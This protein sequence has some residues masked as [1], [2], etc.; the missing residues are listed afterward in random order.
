MLNRLINT[1]VAGGGGGCTDIVDNYD[2]FGGNGVA[3]YQ[4]NGDATDVST[5]YNGSWSGTE[6]Y[7]T[8]VFGQAANFSGTNYIDTSLR[9]GQNWSVS[10]WINSSAF[11]DQQRAAQTFNSIDDVGFQFRGE[12]GGAML[13]WATNN[14]SYNEI[15]SSTI[16][17]ANTWYHIVGTYDY[18]NNIMNLYVNGQNDGS[19]LATE[20]VSSSTYPLRIGQQVGGSDS[21]AYKLDQVRIFNE[22]L[23]PLEVEALYTEELCICDGTVDTL[24]ILG[25]GSCIATYQL[26]GN[27]NDLSGNYSGT[28]TDVSYGVGE[29]DLAGVFNG[30]SSR[31]TIN[32]LAGAGNFFGQIQTFTLSIWFKT[33]STSLSQMFT[34]SAGQSFNLELNI[35]ETL[36]KLS[37]KTRYSDNSLKTTTSNASNL[38]DGAWHNVVVTMSGAYGVRNVYID[39]QFDNSITLGGSSF[40]ATSTQNVVFFSTGSSTFFLNG[41]LDQ[42]RIFNK[43]LS[44]GE[45]TTLYNETACTKAACTG[46]TNTLDILGDGSCI[47][48]YPLDGSPADLSGNYNGVQTDVTYPVG[49]F[50]LAAKFVNVSGTHI[51]TSLPNNDIEGIS[52]WVYFVSGVTVGRP[53]GSTVSSGS[54]NLAIE[55]L[56]D[57]S[58]NAQIQNLYEYTSA[59]ALGATGWKHIV[60]GTDRKLYINGSLISTSGITQSLVSSNMLI[61]ALRLNY[62]SFEGLVD[63]VRIFNKVLSAGEITTLYNETPCN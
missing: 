4:L 54:G 46:T 32:S 21:Q 7:S 61:G 8:G 42:V 14:S 2:P 48:A 29:F 59:G 47:A 34:E 15:T 17:T 58:M 24:D 40:N 49:E 6:S 43:A 37:F 51:Q 35:N 13:F 23:T 30:S 10:F 33:T 41:S 63:Q 11:S 18:T 39:G 31:I 27:A 53:F 5:N 52:F 36:G 44:A 55:L 20:D 12:I 38:N 19:A 56:P 22:A 16:R 62:G 28:P 60:Y 25:D 57:G 9:V 26:D 45:V 50:D 1:K 3:L